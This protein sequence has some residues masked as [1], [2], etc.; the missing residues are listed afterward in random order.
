MNFKEY[1]E[2][3]RKTAIYPRSFSVIY[4]AI[5]LGGESGEVLEKIK[6]IIRDTP[7]ESMPPTADGVMK[8]IRIPED[9][10]QELL[11]ELGDVL[12]YVSNIASDL[13]VPLEDIAELN[14]RKLQSRKD[15]G[16]VQGSGD[17]R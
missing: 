16:A 2:A 6:K 7:Q 15:R 9:R 17:N 1:Q 8:L 5:G 3:A 11:K 13:E 12:W 14:I 4:P 10:K